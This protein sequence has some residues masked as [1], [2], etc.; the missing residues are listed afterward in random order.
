METHELIYALEHGDF[1]RLVNPGALKERIRGMKLQELRIPPRCL[2]SLPNTLWFLLK[3]SDSPKLWNDICTE[4]T[5]VI[6]YA[7]ESFPQLEATLYM[8]VR[9]NG[10]NS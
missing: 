6:D 5:L 8:T 9:E 4:N 10:G 7:K 1:F 3:R 2:P